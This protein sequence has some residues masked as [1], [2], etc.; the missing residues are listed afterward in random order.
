MGGVFISYRR[1]DSQG[2][3]L[4][5][6][7]DL[8]EHFGID[9][10]FMDVTGIEPGKDFRKVIEKAVTTCDVL[11]VMIGTEWIDVTGEDGKR[12]LDDPMDFVRIETAAALRR[13]IP[14]IPVLVQG[15]K[16]PRP[17]QLHAEIEPLAWR[18]AFELRH[19]R[20]TS[21]VAE[22]VTALK[23]IIPGSSTSAAKENKPR[24]GR[25]NLA[26]IL[27]GLTGIVV[28]V[29]AFAVLYLQSSPKE[30]DIV[31][32]ELKAVP[33]VAPPEEVQRQAIVTPKEP[34]TTKKKE[35]DE[36]REAARRETERK[37]KELMEA[38]RREAERK[39]ADRKEADRKE[40][41]RRETE[42]KEAEQKEAERKETERK[43][44]ERKEADRR[45]AERKES[46]RREAERKE[47]ERKRL[48]LQE[49]QRRAHLN[50]ECITGYVW[51]EARTGD[52][53]CVAPNI[54]SQ[55]AAE[56]QSAASRRSP[57]GGAYGANT[58]KQGYVWREAYQGDVVC[59]SP[60]SRKQ[61]AEDNA[62]A[63]QRIVPLP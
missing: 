48:A 31:K 60:A 12:R 19:N 8:K 32:P 15:A 38:E 63:R 22:L 26:G 34:E 46:A 49:A 30:G 47:A 25:G 52:K 24:R 9:R 41:E 13:D 39:D 50:G 3:A 35:E 29:A 44:A 16:M 28:A 37:A 23:K 62:R 57:T 18:N 17:E 51:R 1:E 56:N 42:R 54:R 2:E 6:F 58:C 59:V 53:V 55:T 5:L 21:D 36:R 11:I 27:I 20:W 7:D 43:E 40:A 4:H 33:P 10:V 14:V 45:E 61:A